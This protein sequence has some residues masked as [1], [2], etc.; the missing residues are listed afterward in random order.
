MGTY[1]VKVYTAGGIFP[2]TKDYIYMRL[3]GEEGESDS[4]WISEKVI[5]TDKS[6]GKLQQI[7]IHKETSF[8]LLPDDWLP[9]KIE[10]KTH[11]NETYIFPLYT[12][13]TDDGKHYFREGQGLCKFDHLTHL[14]A[15]NHICPMI[16]P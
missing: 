12:W 7:V 2:Q 11:K 5:K 15:I 10:V 13:I 3:V 6:L 14:I 16:L 9:A 8:H 1:E 4:T